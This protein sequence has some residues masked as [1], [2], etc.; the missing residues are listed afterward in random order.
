ML[1]TPTIICGSFMSYPC[2]LE[3]KLVALSC[4]IG[5]SQLK[6]LFLKNVGI[7]R[8][9]ELLVYF[10]KNKQTG[11]TK[12]HVRCTSIYKNLQ[13][14][15]LKSSFLDLAL[16]ALAHNSWNLYLLVR[17]RLRTCGRCYSHSLR[18]AQPRLAS[19]M[20]GF[21]LSEPADPSAA[22]F[23]ALLEW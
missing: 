6:F 17:R 19:A 11:K 5:G 7:A 15:C 12:V 8:L 23:G 22:A 21:F 9:A 10:K 18:A 14:L 1:S 2:H 3:E 16:Q 20:T 13:G 4:S